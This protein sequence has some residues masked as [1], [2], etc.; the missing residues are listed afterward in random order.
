MLI[1]ESLELLCELL[2]RALAIT[3]PRSD[4]VEFDIQIV[5]ILEGI[6]QREEALGVLRDAT[7]L[8]RPVIDSPGRVVVFD[9]SGTVIDEFRYLFELSDER[10]I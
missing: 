9:V 8:G 4:N 6:D 3:Q 10:I 1:E 7:W 5:G 2:D